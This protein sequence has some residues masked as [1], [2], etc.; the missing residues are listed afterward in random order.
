MYWSSRR[1]LATTSPSNF[2]VGRVNG[3]QRRDPGD[4]RGLAII[5]VAKIGHSRT[6]YHPLE[7]VESSDRKV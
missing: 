7:S 3:L 1:T 4:L 2:C 5:K 6:R